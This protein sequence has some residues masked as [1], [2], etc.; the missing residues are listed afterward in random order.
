MGSD[1]ARPAYVEDVE[2]DEDSDNNRTI[3]GSRVSARASKKE[4]KHR[5]EKRVAKE[6]KKSHSDDGYSSLAV[7]TRADERATVK[8][9]RVL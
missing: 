6:K 2:G 3:R 7:P 9:L 1:K 5:N 4:K 8:E